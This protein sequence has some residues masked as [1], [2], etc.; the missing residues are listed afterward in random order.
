MAFSSLLGTLSAVA[1]LSADLAP[2][3]RHRSQYTRPN[4]V[5]HQAAKAKRKAKNKAAKASRR[6]NKGR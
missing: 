1:V 3:S 5:G 6:R 4:P 2:T